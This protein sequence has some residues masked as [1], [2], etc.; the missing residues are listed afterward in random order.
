MKLPH[1]FSYI[2]TCKLVVLS[3]QKNEVMEYFLEFTI[4]QDL[5]AMGVIMWNP[6]MVI[7]TIITAIIALTRLLCKAYEHAI[8]PSIIFMVFSIVS[9]SKL[10]F[11]TT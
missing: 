8:S 7:D 5:H 3:I 4:I 6:R 2:S 1:A 9:L 11:P 10:H